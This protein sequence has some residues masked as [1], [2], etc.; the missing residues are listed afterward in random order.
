MLIFLSLI[1]NNQDKRKFEILY[2]IYCKKM[3]HVADSILHDIYES[4]DAI[5][6]ALISIAVNIDKIK[7]VYSQSTFSYIM[8]IARNA[9]IDLSRKGKDI[10]YTDE[11]MYLTSTEDDIPNIISSEED[12]NN[13]ISIIQNLPDIYKDVLNLHYINQFTV[14]EMSSLLSRKPSTIKKQITRGK[15]LLAEHMQKAGTRK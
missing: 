4:E 10:I 1:D 6:N 13:V 5:Q 14:S 8:T 15:K 11:E 9:A 12:F 3:F 7:D 2:N